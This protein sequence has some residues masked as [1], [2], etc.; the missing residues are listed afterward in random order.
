MFWQKRACEARK[1]A[2][3]LIIYNAL[4]QVKPI[5]YPA[6]ELEYYV[7]SFF[8]VNTVIMSLLSFNTYS[9]PARLQK[10]MFII[11]LDLDIRT[12]IK[13]WDIEEQKDLY[14]SFSWEFTCIL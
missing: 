14:V 12:L 10:Y 1:W 2:N 7:N 9:N 5:L 8:M 6:S 4:T 3:I 13:L 11:L